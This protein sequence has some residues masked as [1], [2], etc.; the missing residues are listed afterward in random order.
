MTLQV[1]NIVNTAPF[2]Q[3]Q[4]SSHSQCICCPPHFTSRP[5]RNNSFHAIHWEND[6]SAI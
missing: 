4:F 6:S 5:S 2:I 3:Q 1:R